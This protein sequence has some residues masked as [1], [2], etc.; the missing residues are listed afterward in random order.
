M[1]EDK[2]EAMWVG[3]L[4]RC[5]NVLLPEKKIKWATTSVTSL[6]IQF[7]TNEELSIKMNLTEKLAKIKNLAEN[8]SLRRL[9]LVSK[10]PVPWTEMLWLQ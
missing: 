4:N 5:K 9:K 2:T 10:K 8:W 3:S 1:N 7:S 6:G